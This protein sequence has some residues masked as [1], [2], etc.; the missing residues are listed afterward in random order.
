LTAAETR[1]SHSP[2]VP[3]L[4]LHTPIGDISVSE[5]DGAILSV[6]WGWGS[7]QSETPLLRRACEQLHG[8]FDGE[9]VAF[10]L[11]LAPRG[12]A[13]Q[14]RV[15]SAL[16]AIPYGA[17]RS[18]LEIAHT[19]G[20]SARSIGQASGRNP[21]PL[22]IPCHRVIATTHLGGYSGSDGLATKR[23]LLAHEAR[24]QPLM[25]IPSAAA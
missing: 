18:Y 9:L 4:S 15:W 23:W 20:G 2:A 6:D 11:P 22:I 25:P 16:C 3:Q 7:V 1:R 21:I 8:Y 12:T 17:T 14:Q 5:E 24:I 10:D 19:A 13:Y